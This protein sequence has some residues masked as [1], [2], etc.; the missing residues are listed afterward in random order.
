[1]GRALAVSRASRRW[2][3]ET[4][5]AR[6]HAP[7]PRAA[8][9]PTA[10][11]G[12]AQTNMGETDSY[13]DTCKAVVACAQSLVST[14]CTC[15]TSRKGKE[16]LSSLR[17]SDAHSPWF[18]VVV[19]IFKVDHTIPYH[20]HTKNKPHTLI[21]MCPHWHIPQAF[22]IRFELCSVVCDCVSCFVCISYNVSSYFFTHTLILPA[23]HVLHTAARA[24]AL[25]HLLVPR[26]L[27][28]ASCPRRA[29]GAR[30]G[31]PQEVPCVGRLQCPARQGVGPNDKS[32]R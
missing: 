30:S 9:A 13:S 1:M 5:R 28:L 15:Y 19:H 10:E 2:R 18:F 11:C 12:L 17:D 31:T 22:A 25:T 14:R 3:V 29:H 23:V 7:W 24:L 8:R 32:G 4:G 16:T 27:P 20:N 21:S 26:S 6:W